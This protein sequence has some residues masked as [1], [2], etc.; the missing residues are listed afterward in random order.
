[1]RKHRRILSSANFYYSE[2]ATGER[3]GTSAHKGILKSVAKQLLHIFGA[4]VYCKSASDIEP[5]LFSTDF[6]TAARMTQGIVNALN[7]KA[8]DNLD[9]KGRD[10]PM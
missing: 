2:K 5:S 8:G 6:T 3:P 9:A 4:I 10:N 1:M 7:G